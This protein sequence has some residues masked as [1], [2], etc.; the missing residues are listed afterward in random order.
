MG[1]ITSDKMIP[2]LFAKGDN[3]AP[4]AVPADDRCLPMRGEDGDMDEGKGQGARQD[5]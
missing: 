4:S 2:T 5:T 3:L 1:E